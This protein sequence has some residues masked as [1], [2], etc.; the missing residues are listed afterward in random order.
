MKIT[1]ITH[2]YKVQDRKRRK[3]EGKKVGKKP[4]NNI[5]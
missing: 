1:P 4:P 5:A 3:P 2:P